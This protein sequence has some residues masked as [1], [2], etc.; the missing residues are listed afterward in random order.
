MASELRPYDEILARLPKTRRHV[1]AVVGRLRRVAVL[2]E[3]PRILDVF[4]TEEQDQIRMGLAGTQH[5]IIC[6]RLV[7]DTQGGVVPAVEIMIAN[8]TIRKLI[9]EKRDNEILGVIRSSYHEGMIDFGESIRR[10]V[11]EEYIHA[12]TGYAAA[13]NPDELKMRLKGIQVIGGG[14]IG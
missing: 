1:E 13:P 4:P 9:A 10:L 12:R 5:A 6:Q 14:I 3:V 8:S 2:P 7:P 11:E